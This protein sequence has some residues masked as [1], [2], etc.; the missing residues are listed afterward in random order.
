MPEG[1]IL[2]GE[3]RAGPKEG[4]EEGENG[5]KEHESLSDDVMS[6]GLAESGKVWVKTGRGVWGEARARSSRGSWTRERTG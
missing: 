6:E 4:S 1:E 5:T 3:V 2:K